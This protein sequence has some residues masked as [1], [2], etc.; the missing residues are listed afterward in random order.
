M[1][2]TAVRP[3]RFDFAQNWPFDFAQDR[4]FDFAQDRLRQA[5]PE[6]WL[7]WVCARAHPLYPFALNPSKGSARTMAELNACTVPFLQPVR[8]EPVEG[9][10]PTRVS[11]RST[12]RPLRVGQ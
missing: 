2:P 11:A 6:R 3:E 9:L 5:Q 7:D 4:P 12:R 1:R 8:P 10:S